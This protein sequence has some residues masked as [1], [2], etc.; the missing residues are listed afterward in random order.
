M[1]GL[2]NYIIGILANLW[3]AVSS[4]VAAAI[5]T[6]TSFFLDL[7]FNIF[8]Y[9]L[10][11]LQGFIPVEVPNWL[12]SDPTSIWGGLPSTCLDIL[13]KLGVDDA[14]LIVLVAMGVRLSLNFIPSVFTRV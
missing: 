6:V 12:P 7:F 14:L 1:D 11:V 10:S 13:Y 5:D 8:D 9:F 4:W 2:V 3:A